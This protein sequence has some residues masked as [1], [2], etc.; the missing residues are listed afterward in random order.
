MN[1]RRQKNQLELAFT[2]DSQREAARAEEGGTEAFTA[3]RNSERPVSTDR[4]MEVICT[5]ENL[6]RAMLYRGKEAEAAHRAEGSAT[7]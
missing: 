3:D 4:L 7:L 5:P 1:A 6:N 2:S